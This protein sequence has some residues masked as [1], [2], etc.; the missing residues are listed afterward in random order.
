MSRSVVLPAGSAPPLAP[1][2]PGI[3]SDNILYVSGML[4]MDSAGNTVGIGDVRIQTRKVLDSI[5]L[6]VEEAKS[7]M[8]QISYNMIFLKSLTDY[9]GMNEVYRE[10]FPQDPPARFCIRADLV[11]E[12]FLVEISSIVHLSEIR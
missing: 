8:D 6:V 7:S 9:D 12:N 11:R 5:R 2:S 1:Y 10:Y 4:P 3:R